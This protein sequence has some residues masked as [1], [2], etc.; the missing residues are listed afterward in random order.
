M[1]TRKNILLISLDDAFSYWKYASAFGAELKTPNL[2]RICAQSSAFRSAY[3]QVP[4]CGPSRSSFMSG[5]TPHQLGIFD[6]YTNV[7]DVLR[8]EQMWS[9]RLKQDGYY[10]SNAGKVH[11]RFKPLPDHVHNVLYSHAPEHLNIGPGKNA[12]IKNYGGLMKGHGTTDPAY[13]DRYYDA[14]SAASAVKFLTDYNRAAPFYREV[15]FYHPH[16]PYKTPAR[17]KDMYDEASFLQPDAWTAHD[18][19]AF[20]DQFMAENMDNSDINLWRKSVRNY[21]SAFSH[22]D[23]HLG[24]VWDA[25]KASRHADNT[26][27]ILLSDHGYH[28]GDKNRFRKYTLYEEAAGVP[29]IIHD[30]TTPEA[31]EITDPVALL[32]IGPTVLDYA[33]CAPIQH[34]VGTS[35]RPQVD[36]TD[37]LDRAVPTFFFGSASIRKGRYRYTRYQDGSIQLFNLEDD[38]WQLRDLSKSDPRAAKLHRLLIET[39]RD[40]GLEI[41]DATS[42]TPAPNVYTSVTKGALPPDTLTGQG[43]ITAGN[44]TNH[45]TSPGF[46]KQFATLSENG[47]IGLPDGVRALYLAADYKTGAD[48]YGVT[49]NDRGNTINFVGGHNRCLLD[50]NCGA[51]DDTILGYL[52]QMRARLNSGDNT[53]HTGHTGAEIHAGAGHDRIETADGQ[54]QIIGGTGDME[55]ITGQGHDV[56][57]TQ[58]GQNRILCTNGTTEIIVK[59]GQNRIEITGGD[60]TVRMHRTGLPQTILG[61]QDGYIDLS[62]WDIL[63][64]VSVTLQPNGDTHARAGGEFIRFVA[65]KP[66]IV[67]SAI[68][69]GPL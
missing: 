1:S 62:D 45:D 15:G 36:G 55:V 33:D 35:L 58:A 37:V 28:P 18:K 64:P 48:Y 16:S 27:V 52:D 5:L 13:D 63:G 51:G 6:N 10:C 25:L 4:V 11:H 44:L 38:P 41:I 60:I 22:V 59:G 17:F 30:P 23:E 9:Y 54:N 47:T 67:K 56:V 29:I 12:K 26:V 68:M 2:D 46:R 21:F 19:N 43:A 39:C 40:Y 20:A 31:R 53:V 69:A 3:C 57:T 66:D 24:R 32:D 14:Q 7:F 61:L 34:A 42:L 8:P 65:T 50:I 49:G